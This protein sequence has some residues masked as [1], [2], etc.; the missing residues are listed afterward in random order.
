MSIKPS[1]IAI[2]PKDPVVL[3]YKALRKAVGYVAIALPFALG[4]PYL[5]HH[6]P[7]IIQGSISAYYYTG[8]R[9]LFVGSLC[10]ISMFMLCTRGYDKKDEYAGFLSALCAIGVAFCP[11]DPTDINEKMTCF[12]MPPYPHLH[13]VFAVTLFIV[14]GYF[15]LFLFRM[16]DGNP[17]RQKIQRNIIYTICGW[18][19]YIAMATEA[20]LGLAKG[21]IP[22]IGSWWR[23]GHHLLICEAICLWA[24]GYA[25]LIKGEAFFKD[26]PP[27]PTLNL[28]TDNLKP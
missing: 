13:F 3:S 23:D 2:I 8:L 7:H 18:T 12:T 5:I 27:Q 28:T 10:A 16:T 20:L 19:I 25:W 21:F 22:S 11:M 9:N 15:C 24:F 26:V 14:L 17:T 6:S 1:L 4:I